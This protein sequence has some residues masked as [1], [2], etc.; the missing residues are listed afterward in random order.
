MYGSP[1][2]GEKVD[3]DLT[4]DEILK[5]YLSKHEYNYVKL[6]QETPPPPYER[7]QN[8]AYA[9]I[10]HPLPS[11]DSSSSS[12]SRIYTQP[13]FKHLKS[14]KTFKPSELHLLSSQNGQP[15][16]TKKVHKVDVKI[17]EVM[18]KFGFG[19]RNGEGKIIPKYFDSEEGKELWDVWS[20]TESATRVVPVQIP[21]ESSKTS[22]IVNRIGNGISLT[23]KPAAPVI[24]ETENNVT[25]PQ[26]ASEETSS[27]TTETMI[28]QPSIQPKYNKTTY[29]R[30]LKAANNMR[31]KP[32]VMTPTVI[33]SKGK[34]Q[35]NLWEKLNRDKK[36]QRGKI[37]M[38]SLKKLPAV[39][40][41]MEESVHP[42]DEQTVKQDDTVL[43]DTNAKEGEE[44]NHSL[45][46]G[47]PV[48]SDP[49]H[50]FIQ[51]ILEADKE[52]ADFCKGIE[53]DDDLLTK[54][55]ER[56]RKEIKRLYEEH[57]GFGDRFWFV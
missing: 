25:T 13:N 32:V 46:Q 54:L 50:A 33:S 47:K 8:S 24:P 43:L 5:K 9:T 56:D 3:E 57:F 34:P 23:L 55:T 48:A 30:L 53:N 4:E 11:D 22:Y 42:E 10:S 6:L 21:S 29:L 49:M 51:Q 15:K 44:T 52:A 18:D 35:V 20:K 16:S 1:K 41:P 45:S 28:P 39:G 37:G 27:T 17:R 2:T 31:N 14:I 19:S 36:D 40:K 26:P 7:K 12:Y 38:K